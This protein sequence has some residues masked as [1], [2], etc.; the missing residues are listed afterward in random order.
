[1]PSCVSLETCITK[2]VCIYLR[3]KLTYTY[4]SYHDYPSFQ[5][6]PV[7]PLS[8]DNLAQ[9][10][11]LWS[12]SHLRP[13]H[14][15]FTYIILNK[16]LQASR[17]ILW[18]LVIMHTCCKVKSQWLEGIQFNLMERI[19]AKAQISSGQLSDNRFYGAFFL[20]SNAF[21]FGVNYT[22][23][24]SMYNN[25]GLLIFCEFSNRNFPHNPSKIA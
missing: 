8:C 18:M 25:T 24:C 12:R 13:F 6:A 2:T 7:I 10:C 23:T 5:R 11:C 9:K 20:T 3:I 4:C 17:K 19:Q 1:M 16:M 14:Y 21:R 22:A 15:L